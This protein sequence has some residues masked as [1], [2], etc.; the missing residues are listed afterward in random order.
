MSKSFKSFLTNKLPILLATLGPIG[1]IPKASGTFGT[2]V[3][4]PF[5]YLISKF[6]IFPQIIFILF[7]II[8]SVWSS[9]IACRFFQTNDDPKIVIDEFAGY[10]VATFGIVFNSWTLLLSF[11]FFRFLDISKI[12]PINL[13]DRR[14]RTSV[15]VVADDLLAGIF[16]NIA[17]H[18]ILWLIP[19]L[20]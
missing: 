19:S 16:T 5:F 13:I 1:Y 12:Y 8:L 9:S 14:W 7:F 6:Y 10:L 11:L 18:I 17:M 2:A 15:G 20:T 4:I 3:A